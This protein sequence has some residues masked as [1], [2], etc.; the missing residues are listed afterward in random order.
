MRILTKALFYLYILIVLF[1]LVMKTKSMGVKLDLSFFGIPTDK[2][3]HAIL[4]FPFLV[5][6]RINY[7]R[8]AFF[9][10]LFLGIFFCSF[11]ESLHYFIPYREFSIY[12]FYANIV[13]LSIGSL[14]YLF[15]KNSNS[16]K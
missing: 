9:T 8:N 3:I 16:I 14:G 12:D 7:P 15:K 11:C 2:I 6:T 5:F 13:G 4:F 10:C 1:L